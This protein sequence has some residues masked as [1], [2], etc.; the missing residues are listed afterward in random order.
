MKKYLCGCFIP[1]SGSDPESGILAG[2]SGDKLFRNR[3]E[4]EFQDIQHNPSI[5]KDYQLE[6]RQE[7]CQNFQ[8]NI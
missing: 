1:D 3:T 7:I 6:R 8:I 4:S 2:I 5:N